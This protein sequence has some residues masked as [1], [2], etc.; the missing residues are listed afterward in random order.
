LLSIA[1]GYIGILSKKIK[2]NIQ[3]IEIVK[4][5]KR[6]YD[7]SKCKFTFYSIALG[8]FEIFSKLH[9][10]IAHFFQPPPPSDQR[11]FPGWL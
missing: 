10:G 6:L 9:T 1:I 4:A 2:D 3:V 11:A 7:L 5:A 8:L